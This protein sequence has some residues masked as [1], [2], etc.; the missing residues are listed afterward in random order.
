MPVLQLA[1]GTR[2][3]GRYIVRGLLGEGAKGIGDVGG[4]GRRCQQSCAACD[5]KM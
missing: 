4:D 2:I 3:A 5:L 1:E